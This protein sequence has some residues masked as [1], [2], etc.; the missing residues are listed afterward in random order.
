MNGRRLAEGSRIALPIAPGRASVYTPP[1]LSGVNV[2]RGS[3]R[4]ALSSAVEHYL[5]M[6]GVRG[7][8]PL[9]PTIS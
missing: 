4:W 3:G 6:V 8:I 2:A 9:A 7:S 5:D 1:S